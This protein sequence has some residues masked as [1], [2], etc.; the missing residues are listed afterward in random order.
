M[1]IPKTDYYH[2]N[3]TY[4][5]GSVS[6]IYTRNGSLFIGGG[7]QHGSPKS[8]TNFSW[9]GIG[10]AFTAGNLMDCKSNSAQSVD[11][12]VQGASTG[13]SA[14]FFGGGGVSY[15]SANTAVES[16][17]GTP[18]VTFNAVEGM[19]RVFTGGPGW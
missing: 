12:F 9:R 5:V 14:F 19:N 13:G 1:N 16:G 15:N 7:A 10:G 11:N 4:F 6:V 8:V 17:V 18:G 3:I 2:V